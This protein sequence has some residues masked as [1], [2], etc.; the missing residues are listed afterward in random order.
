MLVDLEPQRLLTADQAELVLQGKDDDSCRQAGG[1]QLARALDHRVRPHHLWAFWCVRLRHRSPAPDLTSVSLVLTALFARSSAS[2]FLFSSSDS[3]P[4]V[5]QKD[6]GPQ[7]HTL[8]APFLTAPNTR[9][10][11][12]SKPKLGI[13]TPDYI[14]GFVAG[15]AG[16]FARRLQFGGMTVDLLPQFAAPEHQLIKGISAGDAIP[17]EVCTRGAGLDV[18]RMANAFWRMPFAGVNAT[19]NRR[20]EGSKCFA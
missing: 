11:A 19:E 12:T 2:T 10:R 16:R 18:D 7:C 3:F 4:S 14:V 6:T 17:I 13:V 5:H 9:L 15:M 20:N 1:D 8:M